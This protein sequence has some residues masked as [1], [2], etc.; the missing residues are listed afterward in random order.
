MKL[1]QV[2]A[3]IVLFSSGCAGS[4]IGGKY[5]L[6]NNEQGYAEEARVRQERRYQ[7]ASDRAAFDRICVNPQTDYQVNWCA[8]RSH[9]LDR[10]EDRLERQEDRE[11]ANERDF[12]NRRERRRAEILKKDS[13]DC[14]TTGYGN[15]STTHCQ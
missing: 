7:L 4:V 2:A 6:G 14:T 9:E 5:G 8:M 3:L 12:Q 1:A 13:V 11:D 10:A 15:T